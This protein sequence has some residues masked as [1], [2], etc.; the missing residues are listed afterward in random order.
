MDRQ[1]REKHDV[2]RRWLIACDGQASHEEEAELFGLLAS[3]ERLQE[4]VANVSQDQA[5]LDRCLSEHAGRPRRSMGSAAPGN[6][7]GSADGL[8]VLKPYIREAE[9][10]YLNAWIGSFPLVAGSLAAM[11]FVGVTLGMWMASNQNEDFVVGPVRGYPQQGVRVTKLTNCVW[12]SAPQGISDDTSQ[13][14]DGEVLELLEGFASLSIESA[15]WKAGVQLEGPAAIVL[16][17]EGLPILQ[18]GKMLVDL[19]EMHSSRSFSLDLPLSRL[20]LSAGSKVGVASLDNESDIH[21][22]RGFVTLESLRDLSQTDLLN[23][24]GGILISAGKSCSI[25]SS[26]G[27]ATQA[28]QGEANLGMFDASRLIRGGDIRVTPTYFAAVEQSGPIACYHFEAL[29]NDSFRNAVQDKFHLRAVGAVRVEGLPGNRYA[30]FYVGDTG[31]RHLAT[32]EPIT[33][34]L[35]GDYSI[36]FWMNPSHYHTATIISFLKPELEVIGKDETPLS[37]SKHGMLIELGG[38][39]GDFKIMRPQKLRFLHRNPPGPLG[40][41]QLFSNHLHAVR[42]WQHV[43][44]V[45]S[46]DRMQ[47]FLNGRLIGEQQQQDNLAKGLVALVGQIS[48]GRIDRMYFGELDELAIYDRALS[49]DEIKTHYEAMET[50][51]GHTSA[52]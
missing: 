45:K 8:S 47:L 22:F 9:R 7:E 43:A 5:I 18:Y 37:W 49:K 31:S 25:T 23:E 13:L 19:S 10:G 12:G 24:S 26:Q 30:S 1:E 40:G 52:Y 17:S 2:L 6:V 32:E 34:E 42:E 50:F 33:D 14:R 44:C 16:S 41:T 48:D 35:P 28:I 36:E 27:V 4:L 11:L 15:G 21:V 20:H 3:D 51:A 29:E 39:S 46:A 38:Y